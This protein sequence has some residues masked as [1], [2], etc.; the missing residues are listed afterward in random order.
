MLEWE[1]HEAG[2]EG[3]EERRESKGLLYQHEDLSFNWIPQDPLTALEQGVASAC[4][5]HP[6]AGGGAETGGSL[7][8]IGQAALSN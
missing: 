3:R 6:S 4:V 2:K 8:L 1:D 7:Q 5:Y